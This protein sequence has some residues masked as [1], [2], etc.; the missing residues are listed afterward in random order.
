MNQNQLIE[1]IA[2]E[3]DVT[4]ACAERTLKVA[5][6]AISQALAAGEDVRLTGFGTF[7]V[8]ERA[9]R[10]GRNPQ[11]GEP[12][13]IQAAKRAQFKPGKGLNDALNQ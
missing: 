7:A 9:A 11:T 2:D 4:K 12:M 10:T 8:K 5:T 1:R 6:K 13:Q 3:A